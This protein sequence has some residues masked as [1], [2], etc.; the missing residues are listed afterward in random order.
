MNNKLNTRRAALAAFTLIELLIVV[1]IIAILALIAIPNMLDAQARS[2]VAR[3][4]SDMRTIAT[5]LES[6]AV[7]HNKYVPNY[8]S[9]VYV[10]PTY[11]EAKSYAALSSPI[12]YISTAPIDPFGPETGREERGA[13]YEYY[14]EEAVVADNSYRQA[15]VDAW[16]GSGT[17]WMVTS[18]GPDKKIELVSRNWD[19]P[20]DFLYDPTNGT[21]SRG[22]FGRS[23][24]LASL[25]R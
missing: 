7:D 20:Y 6:Y 24:V 21:V 17:K 13:Y 3:A 1:S 10:P 19:K 5:A 16:L 11:T 25:P 22:D 14:A 23:N 4:K 9:G 15:A 2:K 18:L 12:A 8:D